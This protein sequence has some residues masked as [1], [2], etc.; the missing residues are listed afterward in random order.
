M[1]RNNCIQRPS[2]VAVYKISR[3]NLPSARRYENNS[4]GGNNKTK[5]YEKD[6]FNQG[7]NSFKS[8][9]YSVEEKGFFQDLTL[10]VS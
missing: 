8:Q 5:Q 2:K 1:K 6:I 10:L 3:G 4:V 9:L 7:R